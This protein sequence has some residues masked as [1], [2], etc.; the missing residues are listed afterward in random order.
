MLD[1]PRD[2]MQGRKAGP[3]DADP[4]LGA[5]ARY[6]ADTVKPF[7]SSG[8]AGGGAGGGAAAGAGAGM[9]AASAGAGAA[10]PGGGAS[11]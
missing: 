8:A 11:Q 10:S 6:R 3:A 4:A 5:V 9:G 2:L 1:D 7:V